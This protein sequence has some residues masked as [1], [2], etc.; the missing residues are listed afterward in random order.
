M[1]MGSRDKAAWWKAELDR[2]LNYL[3]FKVFP[4]F[5]S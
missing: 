4:I 1:T 2:T 3:R 5:F